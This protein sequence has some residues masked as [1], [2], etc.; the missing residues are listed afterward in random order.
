MRTHY[1]PQKYLSRF[2][3]QPEPPVVCQYDCRSDKFQSLT[4]KAVG[5]LTNWYSP[6]TEDK[7]SQIEGAAM[8]PMD[9]L[10]ES[11]QQLDDNESK[12]VIKYIASMIQRVPLG[13]ATALTFMTENYDHLRNN[14]EL[15]HQELGI[16]VSVSESYF[17]RFEVDG[18]REKMIEEDSKMILDLPQVEDI[19]EK[20]QWRV[21]LTKSGQLFVTSDAP[22][23]WDKATGIGR[24]G[25]DLT[26]P[27]SSKAVLYLSNESSNRDI[28]YNEVSE[29]V[30]TQLNRR[31]VYNSH[32]FVFSRTS[33]K[34]VKYLAQRRIRPIGRLASMMVR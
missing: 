16:P 20:M 29:R 33:E 4:V 6:L 24:T 3:I 28:E 18:T 12:A 34:W 31:A 32:R 15:V 5:V 11:Q 21:L 1:L 14:P 8:L 7:L 13:R 25:A 23:Y 22:V 19:L 9:K 17:A 10:A 2:A 27:I 30:Q 26:F